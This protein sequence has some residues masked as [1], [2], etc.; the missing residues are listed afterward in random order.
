MKLIDCL[1]PRMRDIKEIADFQDA[2]QPVIDSIEARAQQVLINK[3]PMYADMD[4][5]TTWEEWLHITP[6][7]ADSLEKRRLDI[8]AKLNERLPFTVVQLYRILAGIVG[9]ESLNI[10]TYPGEP[11]I[12]IEFDISER[13]AGESIGSLLKRIIPA[14]VFYKVRH[15]YNAK[16]AEVSAAGAGR[17]R[18]I[19]TIPLNNASKTAVA[20]INRLFKDRKIIEVRNNE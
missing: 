15:I 18:D 8:L 9:E 13:N 4:G 20:P 14:H 2:V 5:I 3:N 6:N 12:D 11:K 16:R 1:P 19:F 7:P 10:V 17:I